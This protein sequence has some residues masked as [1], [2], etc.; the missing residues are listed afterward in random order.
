MKLLQKDGQSFKSSDFQIVR[1]IKESLCHVE[2]EGSKFFEELPPYTKLHDITKQLQEEQKRFKVGEKRENKT[3]ETTEYILPDGTSIQLDNEVK[4]KAPEI[5]F[6]P[7]L[8]GFEYPGIH[9]M[10]NTCI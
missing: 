8:V 10:V 7:G 5:L 9:E 6:Q 2:S 4:S 1:Q 3:A